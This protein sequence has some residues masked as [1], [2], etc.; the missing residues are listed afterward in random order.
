VRKCFLTVKKLNK[1][2]GTFI[3]K[4]NRNN[5]AKNVSNFK[6]CL[7]NLE[8]TYRTLS[9]QHQ[10]MEE[11]PQD[12]AVELIKI[13]K[14]LQPEDFNTGYFNQIIEQQMFTPFQQE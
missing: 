12:D 1:I 2:I 6:R 10:V 11:M 3:D 4:T 13:H 5:A 9:Q 7:Y 8:D 14:Q